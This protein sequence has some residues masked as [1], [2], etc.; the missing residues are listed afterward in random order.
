M[1]APG[2]RFTRSGPRQSGRVLL[3]AVLMSNESSR[4]EQLQAIRHRLSKEEHP[5]TCLHAFWCG[6]QSGYA[7]ATHGFMRPEY[8]SPA[9]FHQ[10]VS[11][12]LGRA[13][14]NAK[15]WPI[16]LREKTAS[17]QEAFEL[18]FRLREEYEEKH[19][20]PN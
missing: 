3:R 17:E 1:D 13:C 19:A 5:F 6:Y 2:V 14:P 8:I 20:E 18:F 11:E 9:G 4:R 10:F 16:L 7:A 15:G 12:R